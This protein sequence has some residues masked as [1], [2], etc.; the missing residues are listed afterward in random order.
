MTCSCGRPGKHHNKTLCR[1]CY[2]RN[3]RNGTLQLLADK[4]P[5]ERFFEKVD[6]V[7]PLGC[8][9][10]AGAK[11]Q[12]GYGA[13]RAT[14]RR[15]VRA[16]RWSYAFLRGD[17]PNGLQ[18]DHLCRVRACVNPWH[19]EPVSGRENVLRGEAPSA[20]AARANTCYRGHVGQ[21]SA[22]GDCLPC[23]QARYAAKAASPEW[24]EERARYER[25][26]W[27]KSNRLHDPIAVAAQATAQAA[28]RT[29]IGDQ[30]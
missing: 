12:N 7:D 30:P 1:A 20:I 11:D 3:R 8:W 23:K 24:R 19:L 4:T 14:G 17:I 5:E 13:F 21:R 22:S 10:W 18:L 25:N 16:H 6:G 28:H 9:V 2:E 15:T 26:R 27:R 29:R